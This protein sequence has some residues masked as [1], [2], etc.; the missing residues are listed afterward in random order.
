MMKD[1]T[2]IY[3]RNPEVFITKS[4]ISIWLLL[5]LADKKWGLKNLVLNMISDS[6]PR[7]N[8]NMLTHFNQFSEEIKTK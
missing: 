7:I 4:C 5:A 1:I 6:R 8:V 3:L 2:L